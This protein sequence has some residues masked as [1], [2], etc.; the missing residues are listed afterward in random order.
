MTAV[1]QRPPYH[2]Q[3]VSRDFPVIAH[4]DVNSP[5]LLVRDGKCCM[6]AVLYY[7]LYNTAA[8]LYIYVC[9]CVVDKMGTF[10]TGRGICN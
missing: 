1:L 10:V 4:V 8:S 2:N 9:V 5:L 3:I 7:I 6:A